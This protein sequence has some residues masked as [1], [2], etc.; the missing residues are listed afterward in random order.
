MQRDQFQPRV[1]LRSAMISLLTSVL[2]ASA[3]A[4]AFTPVPQDPPAKEV[5]DAAESGEPKWITDWEAAKAQAKKE[6]KDLFVD[7]TGSDWCGWCIK[8]HKEVFSHAEFS[9]PASEQFVFVE[10]DFPQ[11]KEQS[12]ELKKQNQG[13]MTQFGVQGFPTIFVL[14]AAGMPYGQTGYQEGGP[15]AYLAHVNGLRQVREQRDALIAKA[16]GSKGAERAKFLADAIE[17]LPADLHRHYMAWMDEIIKLDADG[18]AGL[19]EKFEAAKRKI[20]IASEVEALESS[21]NGFAEKDD[22]AGGATKIEEFVTAHAADLD[23]EVA[24][25]LKYFAGVFRYR[26]GDIAKAVEHVEAAIK[27][28]P[29]SPVAQRLQGQLEQWK[30]ELENKK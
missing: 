14:D 24:Q 10:L 5:K 28:S 30:K 2:F 26:S 16:D 9:G 21:L 25:K 29:E 3:P 19:K 4:V 13:L 23:A 12:E 17:V 15:E 7:F 20:A 27:A 11:K 22:W 8:L 1:E 18:K 6:G